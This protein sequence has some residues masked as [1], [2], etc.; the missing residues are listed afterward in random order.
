VKVF[1]ILGCL[2]RPVG[3]T[4]HRKIFLLGLMIGLGIGI[5]A[6][7]VAERFRLSDFVAIEKMIL[8]QEQSPESRHHGS[9]RLSHPNHQFR[10]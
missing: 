5:M 10:M 8:E 6:G 3:R 4:G 1:T 9:P 2:V 7:R